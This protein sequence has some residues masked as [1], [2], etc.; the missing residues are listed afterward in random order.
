MF[1]ARIRLYAIGSLLVGASVSLSAHHT[2]SAFYDVT[3]HVTLHGTV[4]SVEWKNPHSFIE[5][6]VTGDHDGVAPWVI[7]TQ[8]PYV[9]RQRHV[10]LQTVFKPG[11]TVTVSVCVAKDG[12][13]KGWL[14]TATTSEGTTFDLSSA[15]GC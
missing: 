5:L 6:G 2:L 1:T 7:E 9:L 15:G 8:A 11:E 3:R 12:G 14:S 13:P 4:D 10:D